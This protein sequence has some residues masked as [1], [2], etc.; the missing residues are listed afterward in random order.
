MHRPRD[1][2]GIVKLSVLRTNV[3]CQISL[4]SGKC[5]RNYWAYD[6]LFFLIFIFSFNKTGRST[7]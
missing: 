5:S 7:R 6:V 2:V 3:L 1:R 4:V